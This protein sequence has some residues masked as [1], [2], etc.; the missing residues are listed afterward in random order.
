MATVA[1]AM[2]VT[3]VVAT[4]VYTPWDIRSVRKSH[5][6][7]CSDVALYAFVVIKCRSSFGV[8]NKKNGVL[9]VAGARFVRS[10]GC[11]YRL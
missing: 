8:M 1:T 9:V 7:S 6:R 5:I 3:V 2:A 10:G 4:V 11:C